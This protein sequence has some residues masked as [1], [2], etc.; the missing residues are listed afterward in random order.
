M[1]QDPN[2]SITAPSHLA[3]RVEEASLNA[4]PALQQQFYDGWVLRFAKGFTKRAN[5]IVPLY[6]PVGANGSDIEQRVRYCENLY[7]REGL[8]TVFRLT[9]INP[10]PELDNFLRHRGYDQLDPTSVQVKYLHAAATG[11]STVTSSSNQTQASNLP[12]RFA[13]LGLEAWLDTYS[14]LAAVPDPARRLHGAILGGIQGYCG[15]GVLYASPDAG[16]AALEV[17]VACGLAVS[18]SKYVG[19]FDIITHENQRNL[20]YGRQ[21]VASLLDWGQHNTGAEIAYLQMLES[22]A[23]AAALYQGLGFRPLY[24]YWYRAG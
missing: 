13:T 10:Y 18:E 16:D 23:P 2:A 3:R 17:P 4:W 24:R 12:Y 5:S 9:S 7:A 8:Q 21:L 6:P 15:F 14:A 11:E 1:P 20:G 19:L 22:N